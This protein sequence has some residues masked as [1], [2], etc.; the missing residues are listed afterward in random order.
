MLNYSLPH[1]ICDPIH[2]F[3]RFDDIEKQVIDSRPFQRLRYLHQMGVAYLVYPGATHS[4][5]EHSLGVMELASRLFDTLMSPHHLHLEDLPVEKKDL[6]YWRQILRLAALCH[7]LGHLPF[8]HT[9]EKQLLPQGGHE[10]KTISLIRSEEMRTIWRQLGPKAEEDILKLSVTEEELKTL[11]TGLTLSPWER[12]LSKVI[13]EDNFGAD[14]ID[15]LIRD[16]RHT[17]VGYGHF[18]FHQLIDSL[19]VVKDLKDPSQLTIG[20]E[21]SGMQS[22]ESLWIARYLMYSRVYHHPKVRLFSHYMRRFMVSYYGQVGFPKTLEAYLNQADYHILAALSVWSQ[23]GNRDA[24]VLLKLEKTYE[25]VP[26]DGI[27]EIQLGVLL[28]KLEQTFTHALIVDRLTQKGEKTPEM[29]R[30]F[31]VLK[32]KERNKVVSSVEVSPFLRDIPM[33]SKALRLYA[34]PEKIPSILSLLNKKV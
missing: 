6:F 31:S 1:K 12:V 18:D 22:V 8:S 26:I 17:G 4:R 13:T 10:Q 16:A 29:L 34:L 21:E 14:R 32:E 25:E 11:E 15:Y 30:F 27:D 9:A 2:G 3:I 5:F 24:Q 19:R 28:P 23:T 7:D 20:I 33:G